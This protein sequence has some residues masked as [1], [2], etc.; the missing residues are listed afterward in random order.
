M[1]TQKDPRWYF[2]TWSLVI[3]FVCVGP[4]MLPLVWVHPRFS[5]KLKLVITLV[6]LSITCIITG[7][8]IRSLKSIISY[9]QYE[10]YSR[11][12]RPGF[13]G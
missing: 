12:Y 13:S 8:L 1:G 10:V 6:V 2:K 5:L 9:Y 3:A 11:D 7:I 4:F